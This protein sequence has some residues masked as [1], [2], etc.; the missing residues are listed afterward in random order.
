MQSSSA[1]ESK[2]SPSPGKV[3][4][5]GCSGDD[6]TLYITTCI[7]LDLFVGTKRDP[8]PEN[9]EREPEPSHTSQYCFQILEPDQG[10]TA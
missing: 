10:E 5:Q 2:M 3:Q 6:W 9:K 8:F 7:R 4:S 1:V